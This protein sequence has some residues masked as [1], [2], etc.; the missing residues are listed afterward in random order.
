[1]R[2]AIYLSTASDLC[3]KSQQITVA[4]QERTIINQG[5]QPE[6]GLDSEHHWPSQS[7]AADKSFLISKGRQSTKEMLDIT[8]NVWVD[9]PEHSTSVSVIRLRL[10]YCQHLAHYVLFYSYFIHSHSDPVDSPGGWSRWPWNLE[11]HFQL[12]SPAGPACSRPSRLLDVS[13]GFSSQQL[14]LARAR[15]LAP[16]LHPLF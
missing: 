7:E 15:E 14:Q 2:D 9:G 4:R 3:Q 11:F 8:R 13:A 10:F 6:R 1:M 5:G 12:P 16:L